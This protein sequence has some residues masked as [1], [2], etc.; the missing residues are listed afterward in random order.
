M[1]QCFVT[2]AAC[3]DKSRIAAGDGIVGSFPVPGLESATPQHGFG[4]L[5]I[6]RD[7]QL[8]LVGGSSEVDDGHLA[9][10]AQQN[11]VAGVD[12]AAGG[13][14]DEFALGM[15]LEIGEDLVEGGDFL[16]EVS[17][18][19]PGV[20]GAVGPAHP[21]GHAIDAGVT[22]GLESGGEAELDFVVATH[23][24]ASVGREVLC[25][26]TLSRAGHAN[27]SEAQRLFRIR[28]HRGTKKCN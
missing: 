28:R 26:M 5:Q 6:A 9:A 3:R 27:E 2:L 19:A 12:N 22:A 13:V 11:I 16:G 8:L 1:R 7:E 25:P 23:G 17:G 24:G 10:Q 14:E 18:F 20:G 21:R 15:F 4:V